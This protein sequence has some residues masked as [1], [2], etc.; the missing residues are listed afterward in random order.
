MVHEKMTEI[1]RALVSDDSI[2]VNENTNLLKN[3]GFDSILFVQLL[4]KV[5]DTFDIEIEDEDLDI[6]VIS[7]VGEFEKVIAKYLGE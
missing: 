3:L 6:S 2:E 4:I 1:V 5:E 7:Q